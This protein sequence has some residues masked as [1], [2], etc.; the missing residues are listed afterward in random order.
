MN[1]HDEGKIIIDVFILRQRLIP[2]LASVH[3]TKQLSFML[4]Q[5]CKCGWFLSILRG[6]L[7]SASSPDTHRQCGIH[8][9]HALSAEMWGAGRSWWVPHCDMS[10]CWNCRDRASHHSAV[11]PHRAGGET[12][13]PAQT[14]PGCLQVMGEGLLLTAHL[15]WVL[16]L[17]LAKPVNAIKLMCP[18]G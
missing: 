7:L 6:A 14:F 12:R 4:S 16:S 18:T 13:W 5:L 15:R 11:T 1:Y 2:G 9:A 17:F 8:R 10:S 3:R